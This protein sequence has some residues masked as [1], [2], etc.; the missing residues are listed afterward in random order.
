MVAD[1]NRRYAL[2]SANERAPLEGE[3]ELQRFSALVGGHPYLA[4]RG[5]HALVTRSLDPEAL[6]AQAARDTGPFGDHLRRLWHSLSQ[7]PGLCAALREALRRGAC[8]TDESFYRL[9]SAGVLLGDSPAQVRP[10][11]HLYRLYLQTHLG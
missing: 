9:R 7:D 5:L 11:C 3:A 8:P 6:A 10:R 1:L 2:H 4:R